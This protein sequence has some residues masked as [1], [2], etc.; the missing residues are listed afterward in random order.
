MF[1]SLFIVD[2][3]TIVFVKLILVVLFYGGIE[4]G[5]RSVR[6]EQRATPQPPVE[7]VIDR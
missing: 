4:I 6:A 1:Y 3:G 5:K 7:R 2:F